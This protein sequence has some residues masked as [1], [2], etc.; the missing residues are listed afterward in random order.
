MFLFKNIVDRTIL[1]YQPD[2]IFMQC[3]AD[4][5]KGDTIG[6]FN[7]TIKGHA[8]AVKYILNK[9][10]PTV[11]SGGGGYHVENVAR[12]WAYESMVI[13]GNPPD[14]LMIPEKSKFR[15]SYTE[16]DLLYTRENIHGI[17]RDMNTEDY[18]TKLIKKVF[19]RIDKI[20]NSLPFIDHYEF[21][22]KTQLIDKRHFNEEGKY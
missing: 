9:G 17:K 2:A 20:D 22:N 8:E 10:L 19:T 1:K 12:C 5:L 6:S 21:K 13:S 7:L 14:G 3:G 18:C 4:S 15:T 11:Y 16:P